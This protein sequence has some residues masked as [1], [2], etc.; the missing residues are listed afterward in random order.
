MAPTA[1]THAP[2]SVRDSVL[3]ITKSIPSGKITT[4]TEISEFM[5]ITVRYV[6]NILSRLSPLE[7]DD[8]AWHRVIADAGKLG[9]AKSNF[10]GQSQA[11]L[12]QAEGVA[13]V[14]NKVADH[15]D[16]FVT[17]ASLNSG[18]ARPPEN[19]DA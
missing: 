16:L 6:S 18:V 19:D 14:K 13:F 17:V 12:L 15:Q 11:E 10:R 7:Q 1:K 8:V 4:Y 2:T 3:E 5:R 9:K